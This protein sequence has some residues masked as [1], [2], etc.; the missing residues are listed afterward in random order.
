MIVDLSDL[1]QSVSINT[2]GQSGHP[3]SANYANMI[4]L[5]RNIEYHSMMWS[6]GQV[7]AATVAKLTLKPGE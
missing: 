3:F 5:W 6:R 7:K 4:D 2:T 1:T